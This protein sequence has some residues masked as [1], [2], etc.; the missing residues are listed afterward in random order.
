MVELPDR[1]R[2]ANSSSHVTI[3]YALLLTSRYVES[4]A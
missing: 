3:E 4:S 2:A 1:E